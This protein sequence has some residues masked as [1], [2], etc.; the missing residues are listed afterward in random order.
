MYVFLTFFYVFFKIQKNVT[1]Y[2]FLSCCTRF[3]EQCPK[4]K[5]PEPPL[6]LSSNNADSVLVL[7]Y[8]TACQPAARTDATFGD[9]KGTQPVKISNPKGSSG[10]LE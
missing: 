2:V 7:V 3:P 1:F 8:P 5:T 9:K 4:M 10:D 6:R